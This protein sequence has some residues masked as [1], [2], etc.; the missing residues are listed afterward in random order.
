MDD[1]DDDTPQVVQGIPTTGAP[2]PGLVTLAEAAAE[3]DVSVRTLRRRIADGA[4]PGAV[5][6]PT[7]A[8][9]AWHVVPLELESL[10]Y[11]R[12]S[13]LDDHDDDGVGSALE[14]ARAM[15]DNLLALLDREQTALADAERG[16][17]DAAVEAAIAKTQLA[18]VELAHQRALDAHTLELERLQGER[19]R[20]ADELAQVR[21]RRWWHR[22]T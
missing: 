18:A 21:A 15:I 13:E 16:R 17:R 19:D 4:L 12:R 11:V 6:L 14:P 10:G 3:W 5:M 22:R 20:V 9:D 7:P 1:H 8:G 2:L